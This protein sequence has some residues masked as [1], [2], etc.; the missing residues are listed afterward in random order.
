MGVK[1]S[2]VTESDEIDYS[3]PRPAKLLE[4]GKGDQ[5]PDTRDRD[6]VSK[7]LLESLQPLQRR[8]AADLGWSAARTS[9]ATSLQ[10]APGTK[11]SQGRA[12]Q[13]RPRLRARLHRHPHPG[14]DP[15]QEG[16]R[17]RGA[18]RAPPPRPPRRHLRRAPEGLLAARGLARQGR[19]RAARLDRPGR[20]CR[21]RSSPAR[22][23][24]AS[25]GCIN[26]MLCS[27]LLHASPN[28]ARLVL[29]DPKRVELNHYERLPHL[30]TPVVTN[31]RMAANVLANLIGE[32]ESRYEVME[33]ARARNLVE[34]NRSRK[35]AG[36][37]PLPHILCVIDELADLMMVAPGRGRGLDHP[38]RAEVA[39]R[40]HP[41]RARHAA[42]LDGRHHRHDQGQHPGPDRVLG[43]LAG[44]LPRDPRPGRGRDASSARATCCSGRSAPRA[45]SASRA[46]S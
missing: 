37:P 2:A 31:P 19:L 25:P 34:L 35:R 32:M 11:V 27:I 17:R 10:L 36:K 41:P 18:E 5:G 1:R 24:P 7:A 46:P 39:G 45:C 14:A 13:G 44:R 3:C 29:V 38:P 33:I 6:A 22:R 43:R 8:G 9:A 15:R 28:E 30:L 42:A 40:R 4:K 12:A 26:A 21:T 20:S 23:D 16:R